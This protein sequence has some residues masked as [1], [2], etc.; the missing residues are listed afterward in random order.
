MKSPQPTGGLPAPGAGQDG[1]GALL[2]GRYRLVAR[3]REREGSAEWRGVDEA[4]S[5]PVTVYV[6]SPGPCPVAEVMAAARA[7]CR[8]SDPRLVRI[9]DADDHADPPLVVTV[10]PYGDCLTD[11]L[12]VGPLEPWHAARVI[13]EAA[14]ALAAAHESGL[15]HLCL[16]PESLWCG[17]G[18]E[19]TITGLGITAALTAAQAADPAREDARGLARLLYAALTGYWPAAEPSSLPAATGLGGQVCRPGQMRPGIP[20]VIDSLTCR[21]LSGQARGDEPPILS[22]GQLAME[23]T[24][25]IDPGPLSSASPLPARAPTRPDN[26]PPPDSP[27][28]PASPTLSAS[29]PPSSG[30]APRRMARLRT[31][32]LRTAGLP[33]RLIAVIIVLAVLAAG[34]WLAAREVTAQHRP[35]ATGTAGPARALVPMSAAAFGPQ[36]ESDG[37]DPALAPLAIDSSLTT[38]WHTSWY[39][40]AGFGNLQAGT[41]LLVD[42]GR[43]VTITSAQLTLGKITGA[44]LPLRVGGQPARAALRPVAYATGAGGVVTMRPTG[45]AKG[46]YVLIW[47]TRLPPDGSGTFQ[48]DIYGIRLSGA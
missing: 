20:A 9:L 32:R 45:S 36:G 4:L 42:M 15:A 43:P 24:A 7:A 46:R 16:S 8:V 35:S 41:G 29:P 12:T 21:A 26:P 23:L 38:A 27:P 33:A 25:V 39:T 30:R 13:A 19:V 5:R 47:F 3:L 37:D 2:A 18:G 11:L 40:T 44:D 28:L 14:D 17:A 6:L 1:T 48:A 10:W 34:G 31:A 22:P